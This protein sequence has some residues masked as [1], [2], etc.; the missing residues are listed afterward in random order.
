[1][2]RKVSFIAPIAFFVAIWI[3]NLAGFSATNFNLERAI[4][5]ERALLC[6]ELHR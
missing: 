4:Q 5:K 2:L 3:A 6:E 1:M